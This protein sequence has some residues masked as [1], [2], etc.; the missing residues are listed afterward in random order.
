MISTAWPTERTQTAA[1][2]ARR[3]SAWGAEQ[4]PA[5]PRC[6]CCGIVAMTPRAWCLCC[7]ARHT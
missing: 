2:W 4:V 1:E 5:S 6:R 7:G 3:L